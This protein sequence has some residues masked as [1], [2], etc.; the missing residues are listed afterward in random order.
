MSLA[1]VGFG[2]IRV[3]LVGGGDVE[4]AEQRARATATPARPSVN[5]FAGSRPA[6]QPA[7][8]ATMKTGPP[9]LASK[10]SARGEVTLISSAGADP[11]DSGHYPI[12]GGEAVP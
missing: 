7:S 11:H 10:A 5:G 4:H 9:K 2:L 1:T 3:A 8:A 12:P 6:S